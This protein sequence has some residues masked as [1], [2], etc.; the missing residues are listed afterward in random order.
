MMRDVLRASR[1]KFSRFAASSMRWRVAAFTRAPPRI[2]RET[3]AALTWA[4]RATS[5]KVTF[6]MRTIQEF[7]RVSPQTLRQFRKYAR[8]HGFYAIFL[9]WTMKWGKSEAA[10]H[11]QL[12]KPHTWVRF[13]PAP[14]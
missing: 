13:Q 1:S 9:R 14:P 12:A 2:S 3:V 6:S 7:P 10:E 5:A 11:V 8:F 4:S